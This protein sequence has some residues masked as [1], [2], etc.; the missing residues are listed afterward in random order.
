MTPLTV[1]EYLFLWTLAYSFVGWVYESIVVSIQ[2]RRPVNRG[3]LNGPI[4]PI[5]GVG[6]V[7]AAVILEP[8]RNPVLLFLVGAL[9]ATVLEYLTSW[10]MEKLFDARWWDY[11]Q[12]RFNINGRVCLLGAVIFGT[13]S[14]VIVH[15]VQPLVWRLTVA[16]PLPAVH[17]A[18]AVCAVLLCTD[19]AVTLSGM[20]GFMARVERFGRMAG[21]YGDAARAAVGGYAARA[22]ESFGAGR[23]AVGSAMEGAFRT[24]SR[25]P[26]S[27]LE[28]LRDAA[29]QIFT[30]QQ[31]RMFSAFPE[32]TSLDHRDVIAQL[33][34][35]FAGARRD[36]DGAI[37]EETG[38]EARSD[39]PHR[40]AG[41]RRA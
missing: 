31:R 14:V 5:Y 9:C 16:V 21:R 39:G 24:I 35:A 4:C 17:A 7:G 29:N 1:L 33:H 23:E 25:G 19:I 12:Y 13:F 36:G 22:G 10:A 28:R 8:L 18:A 26:Q 20:S 6:A 30:R 38:G 41:E 40:D 27:S 34:E 2:E 32:F 3:F 11:S 15:W 37:D